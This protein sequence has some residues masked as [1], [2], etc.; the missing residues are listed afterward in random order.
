M[1]C[2]VFSLNKGHVAMVWTF[3]AT[4]EGKVHSRAKGVQVLISLDESLVGF[5]Q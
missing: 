5:L 1:E 4:P 2:E 3:S